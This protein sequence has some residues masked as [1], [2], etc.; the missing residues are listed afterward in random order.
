[1]HFYAQIKPPPP[2]KAVEM[3]KR[4]LNDSSDLESGN[5]MR[6]IVAGDDQG[7]L[8]VLLGILYSKVGLK[9][10][11]PTIQTQWS[12]F[13]QGFLLAIARLLKKV[14]PNSSSQDN[15]SSSVTEIFMLG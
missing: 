14:I 5:A 4:Y 2:A 15:F 13:V 9:S 6:R 10:D 8:Q 7:A 3:V 1:M 11:D 12:T